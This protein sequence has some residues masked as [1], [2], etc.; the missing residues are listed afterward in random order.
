MY[1]SRSLGLTEVAEYWNQVVILN[2]YQKQRFANRIV[3]RL[4]NT[5]TNKRICVFGFAFKKNTGD[6]RESAAI[7]LV[8]NFLDE[9]A[10]VSIYD[11]KVPFE[12]IRRDLSIKDCKC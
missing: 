10:N 11:P 3:K 12:Q 4:F 8:K 5:I 7:T 6:T 1:L 2:E 9:G